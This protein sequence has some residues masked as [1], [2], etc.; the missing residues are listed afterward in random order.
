MVQS[1]FRIFASQW[2]PAPGRLPPGHSVCAIGDVHGQLAHLQ[3]LTGWL[4]GNVL[5]RESGRCDLV[6]LGDY[7]DRGP[8]SI[9]ALSFLGAFDPAGAAL[10]GLIGNHDMFL[11]TF[12]YDPSID[13]D[14]IDLWLANGGGS[15]A[16]ELGVENEDFYR[17]DLQT[18]Q[19]RA[20]ERLPAAAA[21]WLHNLRV[22]ERRGNYVFVHAGVDPR[23][24]LKDHDLQE[25]VTMREPFLS[26]ARWRHD[27]VVVHGHTICGPD[28]KAHRIACDSG[29]F[30]TGVLTSAQIETDRLR[31]VVAA[32]GPG[33]LDE[34]AARGKTVRLDWTECAT[35]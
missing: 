12:L 11:N 4:A 14:F 23:R 19:A 16:L 34:I 32:E 21:R 6:M 35:S 5:P 8:S 13:F 30:A 1:P 31:F 26:G 20:R 9:G 2:L 27:F 28:V 3:A 33:A 10:T 15:T 25:L 29:A 24:P 17:Y 7:V 22:T 18:L